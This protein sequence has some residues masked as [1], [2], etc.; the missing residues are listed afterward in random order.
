MPECA[1]CEEY[2]SPDFV[3]VFGDNNRVVTACLSCRGN[4]PKP[5]KSAGP[6]VPVAT[7][8]T[9]VASES[10]TELGEFEGEPDETI[11]YEES[12]VDQIGTVEPES[13]PEPMVATAG[14]SSTFGFLRSVFLR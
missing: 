2:I 3:R 12:T 5:A 7:E 1:T 13:E 6:T 10:T 4:A 8:P 11:D 9:V 14:R